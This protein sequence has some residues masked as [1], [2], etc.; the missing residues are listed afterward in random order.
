MY[1]T[2]PASYLV[3]MGLAIYIGYKVNKLI[4]EDERKGKEA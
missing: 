2:I 3:Y 1:V 4:K